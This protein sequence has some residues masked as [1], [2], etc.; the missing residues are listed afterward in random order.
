MKNILKNKKL[1][2]GLG[3]AILLIVAIVVVVLVTKPKNENNEIP[4]NNVDTNTNTP[5]AMEETHTMYVSINPL[6]KLVF[7]E[8]Y[9]ICKD[10][11][12]QEYVCGGIATDIIDYELI[13]DD[14]KDIYKDLDFTGK[15]VE[16]VLLILCD[17][18]R[19][20]DI[21]FESLEI[22]TDSNNVDRDALMNYL[23]ENS[24]YE[25]EYT[26]YVNFEEYIDESIIENENTNED[27]TDDNNE[28][29]KDNSNNTSNNENDNN[30][31]DN[32]TTNNSSDNKPNSN[33]DE[34]LTSINLSTTSYFIELRNRPSNV[35]ITK[36]DNISIKIEV[37]G[38]KSLLDK[39][40]I[41]ELSKYKLFVDLSNIEYGTYNLKIQIENTNPN[42]TY[43]I[44]PET[45]E[46]EIKKSNITS[47]ID[48]INLNDN[49]LVEEWP[50]AGMLC[51]SISFVNGNVTDIFPDFYQGALFDTDSFNLIS[52]TLGFNTQKENN[53][54][55]AL[56]QIKANLPVGIINFNYTFV[57]HEF[58]Y[59]WSGLNLYGDYDDFSKEWNS[60]R[61]NWT[62][63]LNTAF[64]GA[65]EFN[66]GCGDIKEP[67]L[68]TEELCN[69]YNLTC[70]RW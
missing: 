61:L 2:I 7:K 55:I 69:K 41:Q 51:G 16:D 37:I 62:S 50:T 67:K 45:F 14:A 3:V 5:V 58:T 29:D 12:N 70:D 32:Q 40:T 13:N 34:E 11:N 15:T 36:A 53:A 47:T 6:V 66:T 64:E 8:E 24:T 27:N 60:Q 26:V 68:L 25:E 21:G 30:P 19:D 1:L 48:R 33:T 31:N 42:F 4:N 43:K 46:I 57:N 52:N 65:T 38:E 49:I 23:K 54:I 56:E 20:N 18:A 35:S 63:K 17:T 39:Y 22:T 44:S 9:T 59:R 28:T 10:E